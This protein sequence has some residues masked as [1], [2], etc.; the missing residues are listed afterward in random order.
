M[1]WAISQADISSR[2]KGECLAA[3][4]VDGAAHAHH[5][6]PGHQHFD[7]V[8]PGRDAACADNRYVRAGAP[9]VVDRFEGNRLDGRAADTAAAVGKNG[10]SAFRVDEQPRHGVDGAERVGSCLHHGAGDTP[11]AGH[12]GGQFDDHRD[13]VGPGC[14]HHKAG[15][16]RRVLGIASKGFAKFAAHIRAGNVD[17]DKIGLG[18][19]HNAGHIAKFC[20]GA[21]KD[22]G[23][24]RNA[25]GASSALAWRSR[26][27]SSSAPGLARPMALISPCSQA[28][29]EGLNVTGPWHRAAAFGRHRAAAVPG[30]PHQQADRCTPDAAGKHQGRG[31]RVTEKRGLQSCHWLGII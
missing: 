17:L 26:P 9:G 8:L 21:G 11:D 20:G 6:S 2:I 12:V 31:E 27:T 25:Q 1:L 15:D 22:A 19:G 29:Q 13:G 18:L 24:K 3:P 30:G 7:G 5:R 23:D 28:T 4:V 16:L 14:R 10:L